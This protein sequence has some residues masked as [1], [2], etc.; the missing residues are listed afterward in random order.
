LIGLLGRRAAPDQLGEAGKI[1]V[2]GD[3]L[4]GMFERNRRELRVGDEIS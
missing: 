2:E 4:T 3:Q 1:A